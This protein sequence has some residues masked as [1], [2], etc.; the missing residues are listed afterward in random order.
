MPIDQNAGN[1]RTLWTVLMCLATVL[2]AGCAAATFNKPG[3]DLRIE[4][5]RNFQLAFIDKFGAPD[6]AF[7]PVTF[8]A[9][10]NQG[11][12]RFQQAIADEKFSARREILENLA[13]LFKAD[14]NHLRSRASRG[15]MTLALATEMKDDTNTVYD[16]ALG[17]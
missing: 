8:D 2:L 6:K 1:G 3:T 7:D 17:R 4:S 11:N 10:V 16:K 12:A 5:L 9:M 15:K 13:E 14:A